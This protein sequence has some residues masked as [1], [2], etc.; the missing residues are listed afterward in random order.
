MRRGADVEREV[1]SRAVRLHSQDRVLLSGDST[2]VFG[3]FP[4]PSVS[5]R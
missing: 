3:E 1:L 5:R 4:R 2:V